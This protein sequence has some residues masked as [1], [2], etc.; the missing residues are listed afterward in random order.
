MEAQR[1]RKAHVMSVLWEHRYQAPWW[2]RNR[3][4]QTFYNPLF[5]AGPGPGLRH[6]RID[7]PD[8]DFLDLHHLDGPAN[9]PRALILHGLEGTLNSFYIARLNEI[10]AGAGWNATTMLFRS[11]GGEINRAPRL[12][13]MGETTDLDHVARL[14]RGRNPG[15]TLYLVGISLGGNVVAKWLGE[16]G[17][18]AA[19]IVDGAAVVSPPFNPLVSAPDFHRI[20]GGFYAKRFLST[21]VPKAL[22]KAEQFPDRL[23]AEKIRA[24]KDFYDFDTH[25]TAALHGFED[26]EDYWRK[27]GCHQFLP[28]IRVPTLLITSEDDPFNPPETVP[29]GADE[30]PWLHPQWTARGGHVGFIAG[31]SPFRARCWYEEQTLRFFLACEA[32]RAAS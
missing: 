25:A 22:D 18:A 28:A 2:L 15:Q 19:G 12:Y 21:L 8:G 14:L 1:I 32:L 30:S 17:E 10:F 27:V 31:R 11:C 23:D 3:H 26:A 16:Q 20:L 6:E 4:A 24:S 13:H 5:R 29:Y 9:A 7:T